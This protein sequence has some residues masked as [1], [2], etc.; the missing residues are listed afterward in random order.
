MTTQTRTKPRTQKAENLK[1][2]AKELYDRN[3]QAMNDFKS[4]HPCV[5]CGQSY[6]APM[7][8][9]AGTYEGITV[10]VMA[11]S[12]CSLEALTQAMIELPLY[13]A[14]HR[15]KARRVKK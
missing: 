8:H 1:R 7:M 4:T 14:A 11:G 12:R 15:P 2:A 10:S 3:M 5:T 13:C 9:F 6:P